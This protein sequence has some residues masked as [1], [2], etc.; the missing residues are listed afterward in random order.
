MA[1][2]E[3]DIANDSRRKFQRSFI[4][5]EKDRKVLFANEVIIPR[6]IIFDRRTE[7]RERKRESRSSRFNLVFLIIAPIKTKFELSTLDVDELGW[8]G[9]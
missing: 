2:A 4:R 7:E 9:V 1:R 6:E 5:R 3:S 8:N